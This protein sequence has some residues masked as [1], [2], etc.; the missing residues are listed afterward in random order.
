M[1]W[2][3]D[4]LWQSTLFAGIAGLLTLAL[5]RNHARLRHSIWLAASCKFLIPLSVLIALGSHIA[6][7]TAPATNLSVVMDEVSQPFTAPP[8]SFLP[9]APPARSPLPAVLLGI[10]ACGFVGIVCS[11]WIRWRRI[12]SA[13]RAASPVNLELPIR[14]MSSP[15]L[16]EPGIFGIFR[17]VLLLPAGI[18]D[19]LTPAQLKAV[20]A[21]ELCHIRHR[22]NLIAA[23]H[24]FV[25]TVFW[26]HPLVWWIGKRLVEERERACDEEVLTQGGEPRV[27]AEAILNVC[28]LYAESPLVCVSGI[29]GS[30]LKKR[31]EAI[32]TNRIALRLN[33]AK[34][35]LLAVT[36]LAAAAAPIAIGLL[37]ASATRAQ[38]PAIHKEFDV[39]S[40]KPS[41]PDEHN[42]FMFRPQPGGLRAVGIPLKMLVMESY[43]VK[44]FQVSGGPSWIATESWDVLAKVDGVEGLIPMAQ[45]RPML[46]AMISD[47]FQLK[48]HKETKEMPVTPL[49]WKRTG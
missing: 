15:T 1:N 11:W 36:G 31:I 38:S 4:H 29:T 17:P 19:R 39:V 5:R 43:E 37:N 47:R 3:A 8:V 21:H 42:S 9:T 13:V 10:W 24:M 45:M 49:S 6:W 14:A 41:V 22:D 23:I 30:D 44:A 20:I 35:L 27:Y 26:F 40:V 7:R 18:F 16:L 12:R 25:E 34:K 28:K 46:Q 2:F 48:F 33:F 32:I